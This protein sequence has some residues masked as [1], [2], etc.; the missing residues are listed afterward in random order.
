M[1][2][3]KTRLAA[4][5]AVG[6]LSC[7]APALAETAPPYSDLLAR[8]ASAPL[9]LEDQAQ[10]DAAQGRLAQARAWRNP[11]LSLEVENFAGDGPLEGFDAAESTLSF[12][13]T[14]E[15]GK[16]GAR[17]AGAAQGLNLARARSR[18]ASADYAA[19]LAQA[20]AE[21]EAA[22]A[23][24]RLSQ[25]LLDAARAD[26]RAATLMVEAGKE[27]H[28]RA[29][30]AQAEEKAA[31]AALEEA[32]A[33]RIAAFGKLSVLAGS[34]APFD[35]LAASLLDRPTG[36]PPVAGAPPAV[37][38]AEAAR[39][40]AAAQ[41]R[42]EQIAARPDLTFSAGL[43]RFEA[44]GSTAAV[45]GVSLPLPLFDRNRGATDAARAELRGAEAR[46]TQA[47]LQAQAD[48]AAARAA[49]SAA[50]SRV[51]S[52]VEGEAAAAEA[53]RLARIGYDAGKL[54][55]LELT[56]ARRALAAARLQTLEAKL[57]RVRAEAEA[58]R[59]TGKTPFGA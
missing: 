24:Q 33:E 4:L 28:L 13:Q 19:E 23:R 37:A 49:A 11:D 53:Y 38:A 34:E 20:Y 31:Q 45:A 41:L 26:A 2:P 52:A 39:D 44:D 16:R 25:D 5:V 59:L 50:A 57:A 9:R 10:I 54:P 42:V 14:L 15:L 40:E 7:V 56:S 1:P 51:A 6:G 30:Q 17:A 21:A 35:A 43:R 12:S 18:Q 55:L 8:S 36:G 47:R 32:R 27:A 58:S 48:V 46:L 3:N 22:D 29:V